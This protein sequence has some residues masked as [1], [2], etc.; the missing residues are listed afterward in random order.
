MPINRRTLLK[1]SAA[2]LAALSAT[3]TCLTHAQSPAQAAWPSKPITLVVPQATGGSSDILGRTVAERLGARLGQAVVVENRVGAGGNIGTGQVANAT[4]D[5]HT[6]V[7]GYVGTLAINP[8]LYGNVPFDP[9][10]SFTNIVGIADVPLVLVVRADF[11]ARSLDELVALARTKSLNF[12]SA[13]NGTMNHMAGEL[14]NQ[15]AKIKVM[16]I[17]YRGVAAS[18]TDVAGGVVDMAFASI[19]SVVQLIKSG[20]LRAISVTSPARSKALPDV[21]TMQESKT[22]QMSVSTWYSL[23]G[24]KGMPAAIVARI[25]GEVVKIFDAPEMRDRLDTL[26]AI[27]WTLGPE[28]LVA[29]IK[30]DLARWT[31]IV[32]ASGAKID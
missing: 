31:P 18:V 1:T 8:A 26:G 9:V 5:G 17:P 10:E 28:Q 19:P 4:P 6:L 27:P 20:R 7:L 3:G 11:P 16:H 2:A 15:T 14:M 21:P 24:P 13:G 29:T 30:Q 12:G 25:H 32:K 23:M 22:A